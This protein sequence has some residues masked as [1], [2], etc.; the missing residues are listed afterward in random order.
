[1]PNFRALKIWPEKS[2]QTE[3]WKTLELGGVARL[4]F[5]RLPGPVFELSD[6]LAVGWFGIYYR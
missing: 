4:D 6:S 3:L 5:R 2:L 1:M